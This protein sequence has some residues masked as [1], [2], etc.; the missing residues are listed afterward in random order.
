MHYRSHKWVEVPHTA[1]ERRRELRVRESK[2]TV[3]LFDIRYQNIDTGK[4][5]TDKIHTINSTTLGDILSGSSLQNSA[6]DHIY[7]EE[8]PKPTKSIK[9]YD[10]VREEKKEKPKEEVRVPKKM[11]TQEQKDRYRE[12][13]KLYRLKEKEFWKKREQ[14][15]KERERI[16]ECEEQERKKNV[17][18]D[19]AIYLAEVEKRLAKEK[20]ELLNS[21]LIYL[22]G[23]NAG[24]K[25]SLGYRVPNNIGKWGAR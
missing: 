18:R 7:C 21:G 9:A 5:D 23:P 25:A 11:L 14:E 19:Y 8:D 1:Y 3:M 13:A 22:N 20:A 6:C 24:E 4:F 15:Q 10:D 16:C 2:H 12:K 17:D